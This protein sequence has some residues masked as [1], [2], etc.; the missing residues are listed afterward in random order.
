VS[1]AMKTRLPLAAAAV[2]LAL[3]AP[4]PASSAEPPVRVW[5]DA[6]TSNEVDDLYA[7]VRALL[8]PRFEVVGLASAQWQSSHWAPPT[9]LEDSQRLNEV[10]LAHLGR[11]DVAHPRGAAARL[12]DWGPDLAQHSAAAYHLIREA[13]RTPDGEK[14][15]VLVLG[16]STNVASAL[17]IDPGIAPRLRLY[18]LGTEYDAARGVWTKLDFNCINDPRAI[19]V[20][21]DTADLET[22]VMP[23]NVAAAMVFSLQEV[24]ARLARRREPLDLLVQRWKQHVD[25]GRRERVIWDLALVQAVIHPSL[26]RERQVRTPPENVERQVW[27]YTGIDAEAMRA[28]FFAVVERYHAEA[29]GR[30]GESDPRAR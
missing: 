11:M 25:P 20:V 19:H 14:L 10:L 12:F 2:L 9:T 13:R 15:T 22:H 8:E 18:L 27:A 6:D 26:A 30:G 21:L 7:I 3:A 4:P 5:I 23:V 29:P 24:E 28:D 1:P 17:L 16:A